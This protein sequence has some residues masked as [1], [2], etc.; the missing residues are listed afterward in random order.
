LRLLFNLKPS[1]QRHIFK[2]IVTI[3][4]QSEIDDP[5]LYQ[6]SIDAQQAINIPFQHSSASYE[7]QISLF[8]FMVSL[9][10]EISVGLVELWRFVPLTCKKLR[11]MLN[12]PLM[13]LFDVEP[14]CRALWQLSGPSDFAVNF[15]LLLRILTLIFG[16][17]LERIVGLLLVGVLLWNDW[18][19]IS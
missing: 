5:L 2:S 8:V 10:H 3:N 1:P 14:R 7:G 12:L 9:D 6:K 11:E 13:N 15:L 16:Q 18:R 19:D 4:I 17:V